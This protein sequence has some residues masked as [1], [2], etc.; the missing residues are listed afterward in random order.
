MTDYKLEVADGGTEI[1]KTRK[2]TKTR[3]QRCE[4]AKTKDSTRGIHMGS[5]VEAVL[6][7]TIALKP[8][9]D[10]LTCECWEVSELWLNVIM[11]CT[12]M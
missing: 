6:R 4:T 2:N 12:H 5:D 1:I 9:S 10:D 7:E 3:V 11:L 8:T